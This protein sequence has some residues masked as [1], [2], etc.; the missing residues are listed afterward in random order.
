MY[1]EVDYISKCIKFFYLSLFKEWK[2]N[3]N[4]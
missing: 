4:D 1:D 2:I 3:K